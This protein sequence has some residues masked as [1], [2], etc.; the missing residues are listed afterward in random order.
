MARLSNEWVLEEQLDKITNRP[1]CILCRSSLDE[2]GNN[3][4]GV[5]EFHDGWF[6]ICPICRGK[7]PDCDQAEH[8]PWYLAKQPPYYA[9]SRKQW[10]AWFQE[11]Y[12]V[13]F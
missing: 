11:K 4:R 1:D 12:G 5:L 2:V 8:E 13:T 10:L 6:W 9:R 7:I 3:E